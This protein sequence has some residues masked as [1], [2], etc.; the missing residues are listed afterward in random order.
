MW[1]CNRNEIE[2]ELTKIDKEFWNKREKM[3]TKHIPVCINWRTGR[4]SV[5]NKPCDKGK[6]HL[7]EIN[8]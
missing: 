4:C 5:D 2:V 3:G 7:E 1:W 6:A 8:D